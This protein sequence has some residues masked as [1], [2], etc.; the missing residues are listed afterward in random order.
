MKMALKRSKNRKHAHGAMRGRCMR[1]WLAASAVFAASFPAAHA[2]SSVT[3][4]GIVDLG[5]DYASNVGSAPNG[6]LVPGQGGKIVQMQS[7]VAQ[8][9]EWGIRGS[10]DLGGGL[11]AVFKLENGF[12]AATGSAFGGL[13]FS[14]NAYVGVKSERYGQLS[15]GKQWDATVDLIEPFT[16]NGNYGGW[17]FAHPN[18]MDNLDNGFPVDNAVKYVSPVVGGVQVEGHY[19]FGGQAGRFSGNA[20]YSVAAVYTGEA[21]GVGAGY[22]RVNDPAVA[23][24]GYSSGPGYA[25]A[26]YGDALANARYQGVFS[27]GAFYTVG[28]VK[29]MAAYS[30]VDFS[31][32]NGGHDSH[33][34]NYELS[35]MYF[36]TPAVTL[37]LGYTYT[38]GRDHGNDAEP[39]Y[40]QGNAIVQ[41]ALSK[42]TA[43]YAMGAYQHAAGAARNAQIAGV[44]PS[45]SRN[46]LVSRIGVT[47]AF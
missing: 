16:L 46:Q 2:Q 5:I 20:S 6:V 11:S 43:I 7:G 19:S 47:H 24:A 38:V 26:I 37:G 45:G 13:A 41:Y 9:S 1:R 36:F 10:E 40:H 23:V 22:L 30:N 4:Y 44:N 28:S 27:A 3:L 29:L 39:K 25:N 32:G 35:G 21:F 34:Q 14:R 31:A 17:Y 18:D 33:F 8:T 12:N 42:R 15:L